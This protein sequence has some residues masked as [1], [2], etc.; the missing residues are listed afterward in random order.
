[1]SLSSNPGPQGPAFSSS[2]TALPRHEYQALKATVMSLNCLPWPASS[3]CQTASITETET[4]SCFPD[5][6]SYCLDSRLPP[7][8]LLL[9]STT[10]LLKEIPLPKHQGYDTKRIRQSL[11]NSTSGNTYRVIYMVYVK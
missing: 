1:M 8:T 5:I 9:S 7:D 4:M 3:H 11:E 2:S 10:A 6:P